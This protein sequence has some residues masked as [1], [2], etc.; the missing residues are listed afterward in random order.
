MARTKRDN[1]NVISISRKT[2]PAR[3]HGKNGASSKHVSPSLPPAAQVQIPFSN[4]HLGKLACAACGSKRIVPVF[5][6]SRYGVHPSEEGHQIAYSHKVLVE[7]ASCGSGH[8][9]SLEH[10]CFDWESVFDQYEWYLISKD[11]MATLNEEIKKC[12]AKM[13]DE[14]KC[15]AHVAMRNAVMHLPSLTW[16]A[17]F[18]SEKHEHTIV[19]MKGERLIF[20]VV[21]RDEKN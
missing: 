5:V 19:V 6:I 18:E 10:D 1:K 21:K 2:E 13:N 12:N 16:T 14:C 4:K 9:E 7:C 17:V 8:V 20:E 15:D 3:A 11:D